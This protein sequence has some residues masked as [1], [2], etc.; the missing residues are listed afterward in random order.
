M[1]QAESVAPGR[2]TAPAAEPR[3]ASGI[4]MRLILAYVE[5]EGGRDAVEAVLQ[6]AGLAG[7]E[8]ELRDENHW[9]ADAT[10]VRL[11]EAAARV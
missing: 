4:T 10:R 6:L 8:S 3:E 7:R 1:A 5:R 11:F 2:T 9:F